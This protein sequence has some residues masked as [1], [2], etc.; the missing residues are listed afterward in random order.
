M[1]FSCKFINFFFKCIF[2]ECYFF[3]RFKSLPNKSI[4][5]NLFWKVPHF[6]VYIH[7]FYFWSSKKNAV[8]QVL[9]TTWTKLCYILFSNYIEKIGRPCNCHW[10]VNQTVHPRN[11][12]TLPRTWP[13][14][15][16]ETWCFWMVTLVATWKQNISYVK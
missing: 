1:F 10:P 12:R 13:R 14:L 3:P 6:I 11:P 7:I 8:S 9:D 15:S 4:A 5:R 16:R 2:P